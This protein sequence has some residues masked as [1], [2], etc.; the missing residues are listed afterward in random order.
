MCARRYVLSHGKRRLRHRAGRKWEQEKGLYLAPMKIGAIIF[1]FFSL[2]LFPGR[3]KKR[4]REKKGAHGGK[5]ENV[6]GRRRRGGK[7][8]KGGKGRDEQ[9]WDTRSSIVRKFGLCHYTR[10]VRTYVRVV[11]EGWAK[12]RRW[13]RPR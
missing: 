4:V 2:L 3:W 13:R 5:V 7:L 10:A 11:E 12:K 1:L 9:S 6:S 8:R